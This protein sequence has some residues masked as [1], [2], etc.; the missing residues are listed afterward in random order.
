MC[1]CVTVPRGDA[2]TACMTVLAASSIDRLMSTPV[3]LPNTLPWPWPWPAPRPYGFIAATRGERGG[4]KFVCVGVG[5][6]RG[7]RWVVEVYLGVY[8]SSLSPSRTFFSPHVS[9]RSTD[10]GGATTEVQHTPG[11]KLR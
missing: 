1:V 4:G 6:G 2:L 5:G 10:G 11:S 7:V 9:D 3:Y 8:H